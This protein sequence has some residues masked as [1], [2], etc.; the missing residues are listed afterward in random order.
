MITLGIIGTGNMGSALIRGWSKRKDITIYAFDVDKEKLNQTREKFQVKT[1]ESASEIIK[2]SQYILLAIKPGQVKPFLETHKGDFN[3]AKCL[4]SI[5]AGISISHLQKGIPSVKKVVRVMPNTPAL[6]GKGMFAICFSPEVEEEVRGKI[7]SLFRSLG[8]VYSIEEKLFDGYTGLIGSG[9]AYVAYF[10]EAMIE[11]G[12]KLGF[13]REIASSMV[14][15]LFS[16]TSE[17]IKRLEI[18]PAQTR[19]MVTSPAG[20]TI[21]GISHLER[22]AARGVIMDAIEEAAKRSKELG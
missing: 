10:M 22:C 21:W 20:T 17:M 11:A 18:G 16:G 14:R 4:I 2:K 3:E 13:S 7:F 15:E 1:G 9:P 8:K 6:I 5:C 12:I 19:E